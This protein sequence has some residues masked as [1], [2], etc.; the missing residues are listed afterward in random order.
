MTSRWKHWPVGRD[1]RTTLRSPMDVE[2]GLDGKTGEI[3][4]LQARP[5]TVKSQAQHNPWK[6]TP[7]RDGPRSG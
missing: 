7:E 2:W 5:E 6:G 1:H 3:F 4:I